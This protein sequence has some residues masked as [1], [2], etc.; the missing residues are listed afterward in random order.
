VELLRAW[1]HATLQHLADDDAT[2]AVEEVEEEPPRREEV[3]EEAG[4]VWELERCGRRGAVHATAVHEL[5][6]QWG[7]EERAAL[8]AELWHSYEA[9]LGQAL[10]RQVRFCRYRVKIQARAEG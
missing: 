10:H 6:R 7:S 2:A 8:L 9:A 3:E 4:E 5:L 1:W